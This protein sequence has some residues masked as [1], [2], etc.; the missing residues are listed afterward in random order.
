[1]KSF[2]P[3][4]SQMP[5]TRSS[6]DRLR[7]REGFLARLEHV[8]G[9]GE[10]GQHD[11]LGAEFDGAADQ[12]EAVRD[13]GFDFRHCRLHLDAG[14]PYLG[15]MI[16]RQVA[17][18]HR[19]TLIWRAPNKKPPTAPNGAMRGLHSLYFTWPTGQDARN[20]GAR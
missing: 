9:I 16:C 14:D 5:A 10:L 19:A 1:L 8:S 3:S 11:Q 17:R 12:T 18:L 7:Q 6:G 13:V 20:D 2:A 15:F 4:R